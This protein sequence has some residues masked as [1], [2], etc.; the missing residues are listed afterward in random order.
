VS[1]E[2][3]KYEYAAPYG[4]FTVPGN[5]TVIVDTENPDGSAVPVQTVI[6]VPKRD[7][8]VEPDDELLISWGTVR[9]GEG[10]VE[11]LPSQFALGQNY[12]NPFNPDTW[13]PY[14]LAQDANV[15]IRIYD[16][17][18]RLVRRL[19]LGYRQAGYYLD[20]DKGVYWDGKNEAG[21]QIASGVYFY[22][23]QAGEFTAAKKSIVTR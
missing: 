5:Y 19:D 14:Q 21:E 16:S 9:D 3:S 10:P 12:P 4:N 22:T 11:P 8:A 18:G 13:I 20:R 7:V 23:I 15:V 1:E 2:G 6:T 17:T